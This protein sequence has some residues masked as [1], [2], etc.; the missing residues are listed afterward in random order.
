MPIT[1]KLSTDG[2]ELAIEIVGRFD[3]SLQMQ[4]RQA[5]ESNRGKPQRYC[6]DMRGADYLDNSALGMLLLLRDY[7]GGDAANVRISHCS[8]EI[9]SALQRANFEK[10]FT[11]E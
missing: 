1:S 5:Y 9:R 4:F 8:A 11:I 10:L 3:F 2:S 7:A 6:I